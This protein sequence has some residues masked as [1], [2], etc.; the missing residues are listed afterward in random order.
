MKTKDQIQKRLKEISQDMFAVGIEISV[1]RWSLSDNPNENTNKE[2]FGFIA[3]KPK[4]VKRKS[5]VTFSR[6]CLR[7]TPC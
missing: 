4:S 1:L 6:K 5:A 2:P 3:R 7:K